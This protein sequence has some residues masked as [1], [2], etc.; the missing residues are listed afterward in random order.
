MN[1]FNYK[2][3]I[4]GQTRWRDLS[5]N[6]LEKLIKIFL[7][8]EDI[9]EKIMDIRCGH[10]LKIREATIEAWPNERET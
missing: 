8:N 6:F 7:P 4:D 1:R 10:P 3:K 5:E 2:Y 9:Q